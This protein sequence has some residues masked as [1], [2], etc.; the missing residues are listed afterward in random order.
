MLGFVAVSTGAIPLPVGA[1]SP[2]VLSFG[3]PRLTV[4]V[5]EVPASASEPAGGSVLTTVPSGSSLFTVSC[6]GSTARPASC[7][8]W[9]LNEGR[10]FDDRYVAPPQKI[11]PEARA[12]D[13]EQGQRRDEHGRGDQGEHPPSP[14]LLPV[15][16]RK[17]REPGASSLGCGGSPV[18]RGLGN[19]LG[20]EAHRGRYWSQALPYPI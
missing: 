20:H 11:L 15:R 13:F 16:G 4:M 18:A 8:V 19:G 14:F 2:S 7:S 12:C 9:H 3:V 1:L 17:R 6:S 10:C 5:T